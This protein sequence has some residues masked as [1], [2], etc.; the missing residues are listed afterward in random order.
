[1]KIIF[2]HVTTE[3]EMYATVQENNSSPDSNI[4][5]VPQ[6]MTHMAFA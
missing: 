4:Q 2:F 5:G 6:N 3:H 1:M